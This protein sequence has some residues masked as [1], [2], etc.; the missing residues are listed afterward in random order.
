M[1]TKF[2]AEAFPDA[3]TIAFNDLLIWRKTPLT[4]PRTNSHSK[5]R[6]DLQ[7]RSLALSTLSSSNATNTNGVP[8]PFKSLP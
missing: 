8:S 6:S 5:S 7:A 4:T 3:R 1:I 2:W